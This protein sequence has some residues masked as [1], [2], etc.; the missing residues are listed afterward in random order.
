MDTGPILLRR[1]VL[2]DPAD[3]ASSLEER[4]S[5]IG[6][7]MIVETIQGLESGDLRPV[8]QDSKQATY[9]P[10]L[11]KRDGWIDWSLPAGVLHNRVRAL[12]PWPG[13]FTR[14]RGKTL[15]VFRS[16]VD[17]TPQNESPGIIGDT[18]PEGI[19]VATAKGYLVLKEIQLEGKK[20]LSARE[21]LL[22]HPLDPGMALGGP[23]PLATAKIQEVNEG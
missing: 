17:E 16:E 8:P 22:G 4:L 7:E 18:M 9:A 21:F 14:L 2:I 13:V 20:R 10:T 15:K 1:A 23:G 12:N 3:T 6:A 5:K 11:Q 19:L